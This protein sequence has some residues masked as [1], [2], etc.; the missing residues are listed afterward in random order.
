MNK[1][2]FFSVGF[3]LSFMGVAFVFVMMMVSIWS[4]ISCDNRR[5]WHEKYGQVKVV[6]GIR[7]QINIQ[8]C[9][10]AIGVC[11]MASVA[12]GF[13]GGECDYF[14]RTTGKT[15]KCACCEW[16]PELSVCRW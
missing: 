13:G 4:A 9:A 16:F 15:V 7:R 8:G 6:N 10:E 1:K 11:E 2:T 12:G 5:D 14:W 3:V